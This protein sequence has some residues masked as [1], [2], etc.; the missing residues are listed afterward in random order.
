MTC[1]YKSNKIFVALALRRVVFG[2]AERH[3]SSPINGISTTKFE[4]FH[5]WNCPPLFVTVEMA[6][7]ESVL[8]GQVYF[9]SFCN[10][11]SGKALEHLRLLFLIQTKKGWG[12]TPGTN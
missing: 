4:S 2:S 10:K 8:K 5:S 9:P 3:L 6:F 7:Y 1:P 11:T 12:R